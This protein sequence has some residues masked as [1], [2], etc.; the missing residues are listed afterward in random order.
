MLFLQGASGDLGPRDGFTGDTDVADQNGRILGYASLAVLEKM[1]PP[2]TGLRFTN[3]MESG[4]L[5]G[6]WS[7]EKVDPSQVHGKTRIDV[8]VPLQNLPSIEE[9]RERWKDVDEGARETRIN[10]AMKLRSGYVIDGTATHPVWI[11]LMGDAIFVGQPGEAYSKFQMELRR[12]HPDR[13]IFVL[14]CTNGPGYMYL[15]T[16]EA[17]ERLR[18]QSWQT[19]VAPGA[20]E[21]IIEA[22]DQAIS[23]LPVA[24]HL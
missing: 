2:A 4:A 18:Y 6:V 19:L 10:R 20:L 17:Y 13:V 23:T 22:T 11:W 7:Q 15:P 14:N 1:P 5:L 3:T 8:E 16:P 12:R 21:A 24:R 9:L